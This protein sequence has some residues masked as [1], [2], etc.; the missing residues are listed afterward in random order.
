MGSP[1]G[2][3]PEATLEATSLLAVLAAG[4]GDPLAAGL[5]RYVIDNPASDTV[6]DLDLAAYARH[7]VEHTPAAAAS[8]AYTVD[9][10]R[11]AVDSRPVRPSASP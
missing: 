1:L 2:A 9:G 5:A 8:F 7:I 4:L 10:V 6:H 11:T 3:D